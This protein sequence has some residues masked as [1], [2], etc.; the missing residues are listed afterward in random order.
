MSHT[1]KDEK[2]TKKFRT[3]LR[4]GR[5]LKLEAKSRKHSRKLKDIDDPRTL[6]RLSANEWDIV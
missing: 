5:R 1:T 4:V 3:K 2:A 6:K